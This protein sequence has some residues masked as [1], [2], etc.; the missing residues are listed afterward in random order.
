MK[1]NSCVKIAKTFLAKNI[2]KMRSY[3]QL[4][5]EIIHSKICQGIFCKSIPFH[6]VEGVIFEI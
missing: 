1:T 2:S 3:D 5:K 4:S 6:K